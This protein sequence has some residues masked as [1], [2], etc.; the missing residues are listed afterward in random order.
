V[1]NIKATGLLSTSD[2][3]LKTNIR[4]IEGLEIVTKLKGVRFDWIATGNPDI[5]LIAQEVEE[6]VP[7]AVVTDRNT[8]YKSVKYQNLI[9]ALIE[10]TKELDNA[11]HV[12]TTKTFEIELE[13]L[14]LNREIATL[15]EKNAELERRLRLIEQALGIQ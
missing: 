15:K 13:N 8:G 14:R 5:G 2:R 6:V 12:A 10:S 9:A 4:P 7:E 1:G 3:R 11:C